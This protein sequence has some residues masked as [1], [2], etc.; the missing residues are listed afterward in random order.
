[1]AK[2]KK[3]ELPA[4]V[5]KVYQAHARTGRFPSGTP[6]FGFEYTTP[7]AP[8]LVDRLKEGR[9]ATELNFIDGQTVLRLCGAYGEPGTTVPVDSPEDAL[10]KAAAYCSTKKGREKKRKKIEEP[11][12]ERDPVVGFSDLPQPRPQ[13][14][15]RPQRPAPSFNRQAAWLLGGT[16]AGLLA[17]RLLSKPA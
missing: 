4:A 12:P 9:C 13:R 17:L 11:M 6:P 1:M 15:Q 16:A 3:V 5:G 14:P 10:E 2:A 7:G 8:C